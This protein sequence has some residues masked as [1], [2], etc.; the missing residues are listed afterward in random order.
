MK[1]YRVILSD[2]KTVIVKAEG[3]SLFTEKGCVKFFAEGKDVAIFD[4]YNILGFVEEESVIVARAN[5]YNRE[6]VLM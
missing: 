5:T 4:F 2:N 6:T 1:K 3:F